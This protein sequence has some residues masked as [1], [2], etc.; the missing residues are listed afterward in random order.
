MD[1]DV[2]PGVPPLMLPLLPPLLLLLL[3]LLPN[4]GACAALRACAAMRR[5]SSCVAW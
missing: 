1:D 2:T 4:A 5:L 3:L